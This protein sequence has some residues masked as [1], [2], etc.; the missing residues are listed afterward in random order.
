MSMH[1]ACLA[2]SCSAAA[3]LGRDSRVYTPCADV[4]DSRLLHSPSH[5]GAGIPS[6]ERV[7]DRKIEGKSNNSPI[8]LAGLGADA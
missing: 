5:A 8:V 4:L 7:M 6:Q 1:R 3:A 2:I